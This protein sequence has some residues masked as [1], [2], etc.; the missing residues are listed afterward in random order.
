MTTKTGE[1]L[2]GRKRDPSVLE[3]AW[4]TRRANKRKAKRSL[5]AALR[6]GTTGIT[7]RTGSR[8]P[9]RKVKKARTSPAPTRGRSKPEAIL[10]GINAPL[11]ATHDAM[12]EALYGDNAKPMRATA[13]GPDLSPHTPDGL[14]ITAHM[15]TVEARKKTGGDVEGILRATIHGAK[16]A[17]QVRIEEGAARQRREHLRVTSQKIVCGFI[18][19]VDMA[20]AHARGGLPPNMVWNLNSFTVT[21]IVDA[22]NA[23]GYYGNG[24]RDP[25]TR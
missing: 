4:A 14:A 17:E 11:A 20:M 6:S 19:E 2:R 22:L 21:K 13:N 3:K 12:T 10:A 9:I 24:F 16:M 7:V 5:K 18:A 25:V 1:K 15:L 23:A 8:T